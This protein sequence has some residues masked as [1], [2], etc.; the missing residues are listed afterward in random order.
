MFRAPTGSTQWISL[1]DIEVDVHVE[2]NGRVYAGIIIKAIRTGAILLFKVHSKI[3]CYHPFEQSLKAP[4]GLR[5]NEAFLNG[6][7]AKLETFVSD[8]VGSE[9]AINVHCNPNSGGNRAKTVT[10]ELWASDHGL[11]R[12]LKRMAAMVRAAM[13]TGGGTGLS[14]TP[15]LLEC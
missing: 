14:I 2:S 5:R 10:C 6:L 7:K 4:P 8:L 11:Y 9:C 13:D 15:Q 12:E 1:G 3:S